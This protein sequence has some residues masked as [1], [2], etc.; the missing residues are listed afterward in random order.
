MQVIL[1]LQLIF[2]FSFSAKEV[3]CTTTRLSNEADANRKKKV[4][5]VF[6]HLKKVTE[7]V[8]K[9]LSKVQKE[10]R[11]LQSRQVTRS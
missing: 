4:F 8:I 6:E 5:L 7:K 1:N 10:E 2:F 11:C 3:S 9:L